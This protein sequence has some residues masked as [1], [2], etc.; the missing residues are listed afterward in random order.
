MNVHEHLCVI[1][2]ECVRVPEGG[3]GEGSEARGGGG[4]TVN[5]RAG[6]YFMNKAFKSEQEQLVSTVRLLGPPH[7]D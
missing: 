2:Q 6:K 4:L 1:V 5:R 7:P 3:E